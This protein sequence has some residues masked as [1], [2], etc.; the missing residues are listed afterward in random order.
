MQKVGD[1]ISE[2]IS[3]NT[4]LVSARIAQQKISEI[5][6]NEELKKQYE[7]FKD[8]VG[9]MRYGIVK[10]VEYSDLIIDINGIGAYLPF[11]KLNWW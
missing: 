10:Q 5:I 7:E 3:L 6:K 4:D 11:T 9:E 2:L 1:T 8:K